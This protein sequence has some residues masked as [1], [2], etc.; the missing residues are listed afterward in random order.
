[1][2][3]LS[4]RNTFFRLFSFFCLLGVHFSLYA[5][6][7]FT[8]SFW[9]LGE[10][11]QGVVVTLD[12]EIKNTGLEAVDVEFI[13]TCDCFYPQ[14]YKV[15]IP[16][17]E[18]RLVTFFYDSSD[19][20]GS[21][22]KYVI[23]LTTDPDLPKGLFQASGVVPMKDAGPS[24]ATPVEEQP[25]EPGELVVEY[26]YSPTCKSCIEFLQKEV[27]RIEKKLSVDLSMKSVDVLEG[28]NFE[29]FQKKIDELGIESNA[30]PVLILGNT[31]LQGEK[32]I[33]R[34]FRKAVTAEIQGSQYTAPVYRPGLE[35][36]GGDKLLVLPVI[37]AGLLDGINPCAFTTLIFLLAALTL[38]G[39]SRR[40][41]LIIG[42]FFTATVFV[43]YALIGLG[44]FKTLRLAGSFPIIGKIIRVILVAVLLIFAGISF[45]DYR[46]IK[47]GRAKDIILQLPTAMKKRI[48]TSVRTYTR[49]G[50]LVGSSILMGFFVSVFELGCTGQVYFPTIAYLVQVEQQMVGYLLLLVYNL[51]FIVPLATVFLLTYTGV[52]SEK[53]TGLFQRHLGKVK[54]GTGILFIGLAVLT[55]LT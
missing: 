18:T 8:P 7:L 35:M 41:I 26:Y 37:L 23:V 4:R 11:K 30:F 54:I 25:E 29:A 36:V 31:V 20:Q 27:P 21:F 33:H 47:K 2:K 52:S 19:D 42:L 6:I 22:E 1:M 32:D 3:I 13:S 40:E 9:D 28:K 43:T 39:K 51:G 44:F 49:S 48:H 10:L 5:E 46:I 14:D 15:S 12:V 16:R 38:A 24:S 53:I 45:Y 17:E 50:A 55:L 34:E